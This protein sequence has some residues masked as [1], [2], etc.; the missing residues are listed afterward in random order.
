MPKRIVCVDDQA[1]MRALVKSVL[2]KE[3]PSLVFVGCS[4]GEEIINRMAELQPDLLILDLSLGDMTGVDV[5]ERT[6]Q[7]REDYGTVVLFMTGHTKVTMTDHYRDLGVV[8][9]LH[10]PFY[11]EELIDAVAAAIFA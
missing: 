10:K 8:G 5:L 11:P 4:S 2:L 6:R 3:D 1:D 7:K 9:V